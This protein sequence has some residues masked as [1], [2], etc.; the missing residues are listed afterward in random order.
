MLCG[1]KHGL[2]T[3]QTLRHEGIGPNWC[4]S[5][6]QSWL[7][8]GHSCSFTPALAIYIFMDLTLSMC[9]VM[10]EKLWLCPIVPVKGNVNTKAYKCSLDNCA[11][12]TLFN[13]QF[14]QRL[15]C[16]WYGHVCKYFW[17][18]SVSW[19]LETNP[20]K[21]QTWGKLPSEVSLF[22]ENRSP[23]YPD[24]NNHS[25]CTYI[26]VLK[27]FQAEFLSAWTGESLTCGGV[28]AGSPGGARRA[29][30]DSWAWSPH[31]RI[32][33]TAGPACQA[34]A[35][36]ICCPFSPKCCQIW[37]DMSGG[38]EEKEGQG[39]VLHHPEAMTLCTYSCTRSHASITKCCMICFTV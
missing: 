35:F 4:S 5:A 31:P 11:F 24:L 6:S 25:L 13:R 30:L 17:P 10:L 34:G 23:K 7:I 18:Y 33:F 36:V 3:I 26:F 8:S 9:I 28:T 1:L 38:E 15:S 20:L 37:C 21:T 32:T 27:P 12:P 39:V 14:M 29:H 2:R 16:A 19:A 22:Q